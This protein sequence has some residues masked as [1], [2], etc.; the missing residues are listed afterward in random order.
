MTLEQA[1]TEI[2]TNFMSGDYFDSHTV[3]N[4]L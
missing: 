3:I 2:L 4:A 1:V